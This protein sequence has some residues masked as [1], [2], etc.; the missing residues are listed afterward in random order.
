MFYSALSVTSVPVDGNG[1]V[2]VPAN[3]SG[4]VYAIATSSE[5]EVTDKTIL[6]SP[7]V[8]LFE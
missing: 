8:L 4:R 3:I 2:A 5:T 1:Q 7:A 6:T